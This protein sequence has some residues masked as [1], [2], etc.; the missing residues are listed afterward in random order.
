MN[1]AQ[2]SAD[3][4]TRDPETPPPLDRGPSLRRLSRN[5]EALA[6]SRPNRRREDTR[7]TLADSRDRNSIVSEEN[8][9]N[10]RHPLLP[11][12]SYHCD[13]TTV[14]VADLLTQSRQ[15]HARYRRLSHDTKNTHLLAQGEAIQAALLARLSAEHLD[16]A[17]DDPAWLEDAQAQKGLT[18]DELI[19]F[20]GRYLA[21]TE[22]GL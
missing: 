22:A 8:R 17:H 2:T 11:L 5:R 7:G 18:S 1:P 10:S 9:R 12:A 4:R 16:P 13:T 15:A 19:T 21:P 6:L 3:G 14:S 20:Y